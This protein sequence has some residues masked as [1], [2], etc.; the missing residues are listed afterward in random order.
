MHANSRRDPAAR[1]SNFLPLK[2]LFCLMDTIKRQALQVTAL[3]YHFALCWQQNKQKNHKSRWKISKN[4]YCATAR[5][6]ELNVNSPFG[7]HKGMI[8]VRV[9]DNLW[10]S[11]LAKYF[12]AWHVWLL[13]YETLNSLSMRFLK[14]NSIAIQENNFALPLW[15]F[16]K[17]PS[18]PAYISWG[19]AP[20]KL[21]FRNIQKKIWLHSEF[22]YQVHFVI[23]YC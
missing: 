16:W 10:T 14:N 18:Y 2:D 6:Q 23:N 3:D 12:I 17:I 15:S 9:F 4:N 8:N 19:S 22:S 21:M 5:T 20:L 7:V 11:E 1:S 13:C